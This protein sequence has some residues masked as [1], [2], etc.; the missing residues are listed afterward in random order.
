VPRRKLWELEVFEEEMVF[1]RELVG[2][3]RK[4]RAFLLGPLREPVS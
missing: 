3:K 1:R 4:G 2:E